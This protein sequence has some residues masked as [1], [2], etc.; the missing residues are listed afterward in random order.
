MT[1]SVPVMCFIKVW[2]SLAAPGEPQSLIPA[3]AHV[4]ALF[5]LARL[6]ASST[7][8]NHYPLSPIISPPSLSLSP[9]GGGQHKEQHIYKQQT[10][11]C[12]SVEGQVWFLQAPSESCNTRKHL[13]INSAE[14]VH[15]QGHVHA[16]AKYGWMLKFY[17]VHTQS[18]V[19][20]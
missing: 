18:L 19:I 8:N 5:S 12:S 2:L 6:T 16:D 1:K 14:I 20:Y 11:T 3:A 10:L 4:A 9:S 13:F 7:H 17:S 15:L